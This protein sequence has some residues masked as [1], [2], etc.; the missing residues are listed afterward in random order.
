MVVSVRAWAS[1]WI[2]PVHLLVV[3]L[4]AL[5]GATPV[6]SATD[7]LDEISRRLEHPLT[8]LIQISPVIPSPFW[9]R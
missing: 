8:D 2:R 7:S 3:G 1:G 5:V 9:I 4:I 6:A